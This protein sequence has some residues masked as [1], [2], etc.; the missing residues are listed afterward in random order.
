[1]SPEGG[2]EAP[3]HVNGLRAA[4][5]FI[6]NNLLYKSM[7]KTLFLSA[8]CVAL[9][10]HAFGA[11]TYEK[12]LSDTV[13]ASS[14]TVGDTQNPYIVLG[15]GSLKFDLTQTLVDWSVQLSLDFD[16]GSVHK[17]L[18][19]IN[20]DACSFFAPG[21]G[22]TTNTANTFNINVKKTN[23]EG[24]VAM[25]KYG[26]GFSG[27]GDECLTFSA[28]DTLTLSYSHADDCFT[29]SNG[30][31]AITYSASNL[32]TVKTLS[33]GNSRLF[34]QSQKVPV[35]VLAVEGK[36]WE[37]VITLENGTKK[38]YNDEKT[39]VYTTNRTS[40]I[41]SD[42]G[43]EAY[44]VDGTA[45]L[46][47]AA[48]GSD[49]AD[50]TFAGD[51]YLQSTGAG[52]PDNHGA[53]RLD[54]S[55]GHTLTLNGAVVLGADTT[56]TSHKNNTDDFGKVVFN[57]AVTGDHTL[58]LNHRVK[59]DDGSPVEFKKT[60]DVKNLNISTTA[61]FAELH[62]GSIAATGGTV[63]V[64]NLVVD[65]GKTTTLSVSNATL[66]INALTMGAGSVLTFGTEES[67]NND[68][69]TSGLT[70]GGEATL[71]ANLVMNS[72]M[73]T[74]ADKAILT[75][76]CDVT[77]GYEAGSNVTVV[78]TDTMVQSIKDGGLVEIIAGVDNAYLGQSLTFIGSG[79]MSD[80]VT[81][82]EAEYSLKQVGDKI[83]ITPEPA[84]ATL[85]LLALA[86]LASRRRRH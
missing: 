35:K 49:A 54:T 32:T 34:T 17:T 20:Q 2:A 62:T 71:N 86:G 61:T 19:N 79:T 63:T 59:Q 48:T 31:S 16:A 11:V 44:I 5:A 45:Q 77:I 74:F 4:S 42:P 55:A 39:S 43:A 26:N 67:H 12:R 81:E 8:L 18:S 75:M 85:S 36:Y 25:L 7:K 70:V 80:Y 72:G 33:S 47:F 9:C 53:L 21:A 3:Y 30:T 41:H 84:T 1:M 56:I 78:L 51:I 27:T 24:P 6:I 40:A 13:H 82:H 69:I 46:W 23:T 76:G 57:G 83:F 73:L 14:I 60:V 37:K 50:V 52:A 64:Q 68:L 66:A 28:T 15:N 22:S 29:L 10:G 58:T 38:L 65:A